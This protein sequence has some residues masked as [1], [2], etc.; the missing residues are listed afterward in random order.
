M[1]GTDTETTNGSADSPTRRINAST[2]LLVLGYLSVG[3]TLLLWWA[4]TWPDAQVPDGGRE[5]FGNVPEGCV[6]D[7]LPGHV[8]VTQTGLQGEQTS[9]G[10]WACGAS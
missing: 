6:T 1:P 10:D 4:G 9:L 7:P 2:A 5:V 3:G 8:A